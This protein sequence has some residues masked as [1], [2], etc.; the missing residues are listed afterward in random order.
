MDRSSDGGMTRMV[1]E[2]SLRAEILEEL[3]GRRGL[4]PEELLRSVRLGHVAKAIDELLFFT[5]PK[6][7]A[8]LVGDVERALR[9]GFVSASGDEQAWSLEFATDLA[10]R[11]S[12]YM[13]RWNLVDAARHSRSALSLEEVRVC[14]GRAKD[15]ALW[16]ATEQP[17]IARTLLDERRA[18]AAVRLKAE[19]APEP[20]AAAQAWV[21]DS[22]DDYL[23]NFHQ[24]VEASNLRRIAELRAGGKTR[25]EISNDYA[26]FLP[27]ALHLG[28]SFVTCNPPLVD[29]AWQADPPRWNGVADRLLAADPEAS[30]DDLARQMT[31][32]VVLS[33]MHLLR[34]IFLLTAGQTGCVSLQV[35]P[36]RHDDAESMIRD[37]TSIY[38]ELRRRLNGGVPNVVFKL[39][40]TWAGLQACRALTSDGIGVNITVNFALFQHLRFA[41]AIQAGQSL[42]SVLS[43]MSGRLAFPVRDELLAMLGELARHGIDES[44]V[45]QAAAWSG[46]IVL[47]RLHQLLL[48][49]GYDLARVKPLI[50]SMRIYEGEMYRGLPSPI[51][52]ISEVVGTGILT[53]FPNVRRAFDSLPK[54]EIGPGQIEASPP[55]WA[56]PI[57]AHSEIFRQ[58]YYVQA[59]GWGD[60]GKE[61]RP[62]RVLALEDVSATADWLPVRNTLNEFCKAYDVF[63]E[64]IEG[65][66]RLMDLQRTAPS[67]SAWTPA[68][69]TC[70]TRALMHFD[71]STVKETLQWLCSIEPNQTVGVVLRSSEVCQALQSRGDAQLEPI[72]AQ[73]LARHAS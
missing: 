13:P 22:L 37:A 30:G 73:A 26:A 55:G 20:V 8:S 7:F 3:K 66:R 69:G 59:R 65:R 61:M 4:S 41:E 6:D 54:L 58:A 24:A 48:A 67:S 10:T 71:I 52:D 56:L 18:D 14:A 12:S 68:E 33:N 23:T 64:R 47:K 28:A 21:G 70:L 42:F 36:K 45:R 63:V 1:T 43:H 2:E 62:E 44:Q 17:A 31:L 16:M 57:L 60:D 34:P 72:Q 39:P 32:E 46:I 19:A 38:Q 53:V 40:A 5:P 11:L 49:R 15:L 9:S 27:Y 25:S 29:I 51:P 35:N 50:A